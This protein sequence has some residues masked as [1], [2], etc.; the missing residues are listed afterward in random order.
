VSALERSGWD[1][2]FVTTIKVT[3]APGQVAL[4]LPE[5]N[6]LLYTYGLAFL[7]ALMLAE[8]TKAWKILVGMVVLLPFQVW[9][10]A[11]DVLAQ[12]GVRLGPDVAALAG[13]TGWRTEAIALG[14]QL[15]IL[16]FPT[17]VP[18]AVWAAFSR[19]FSESVLSAQANAQSRDAVF[20]ESRFPP[21]PHDPAGRQS[22]Q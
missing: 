5:V 11:F 18:V 2:V 20:T 9:G 7:L 4:L 15:G 6:P 3:P 8:R 17:L 14:Y 22:A 1:L 16:I 13:L 10:I 19:L 21:R 12:V